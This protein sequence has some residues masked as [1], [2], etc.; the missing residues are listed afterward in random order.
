MEQFMG[1]SDDCIFVDKTTGAMQSF[2][3]KIYKPPN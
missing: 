3:M 1:E 2:T